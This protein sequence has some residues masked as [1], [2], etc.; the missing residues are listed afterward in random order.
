MLGEV[1]ARNLD[2]GVGDAVEIEGE[3]FRV[4]GVFRSFNVFENGSVIAPL[5]EVQR[6]QLRE[7]RITGMSVVLEQSKKDTPSKDE[8]QAFVN[9]VCEQINALQ[10]DDGNSARL[11][12]QQVRDYAAAA[13][14]LKM[15][16]SMAWLTSAIAIIVG[17]IGVANTMI[18]SVVERV[19]EISILR[20]IGWRRSRVVRMIVG[21]SLLLSL[22][23][24]TV[25]S[26]GAVVLARYL[27]T[28]PMVSGYIDGSIAPG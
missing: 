4:V 11:A 16:N 22:V 10:D 6:V 21:E 5:K 13:M 7:G 26:I 27:T 18:M 24:A 9:S 19:R 15:A 25:G 8:A 12:A 28:L 1:A 23:G 20:A 14:H 2:K 17:T 3:A